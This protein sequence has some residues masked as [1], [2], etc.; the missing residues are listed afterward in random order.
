[1]RNCKAIEPSNLWFAEV[2]LCEIN[3]GY[4]NSQVNSRELKG[5]RVFLVCVWEGLCHLSTQS[6]DS[7][8]GLV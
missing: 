4:L 6:K 2:F 7:S 1:M 8:Q 5:Y 3:K